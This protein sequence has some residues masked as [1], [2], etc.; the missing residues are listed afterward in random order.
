[1]DIENILTTIR[2]TTAPDATPDARAAGAAACRALLATL[3][4]AP[5]A[6]PDAPSMQLNASAV[7]SAIS[8]LRGIAPEQLLDLAIAKLRAAL[9][10][11]AQV[12]R[13]RPLDF[14]IIRVP[15]RSAS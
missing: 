9:P 5:R 4:P 2:A 7:A 3:E 1:M 13:V 12:P 14:H 15:G 6:Q 8:A 11:D 10:P